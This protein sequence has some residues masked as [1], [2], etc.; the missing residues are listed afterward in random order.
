MSIL[1]GIQKLQDL[2]FYEDT[3]FTHR[4]LSGGYVFKAISCV[5]ESEWWYHAWVDD[6]GQVRLHP[7]ATQEDA[8]ACLERPVDF[9]LCG[10]CKQN[11]VKWVDS[12]DFDHHKHSTN[13][14]QDM[15]HW[16]CPHCDSTYPFQ[17]YPS[18]E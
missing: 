7:Q 16:Q 18:P 17:L 12:V 1:N 14:R 4:D 9:H 10:H 6:E 2:F 8:V 5:N 15:G 11:N 13:E 3:V